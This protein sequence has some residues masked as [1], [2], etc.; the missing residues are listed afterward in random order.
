MSEPLDVR[1]L[2]QEQE[3]KLPT[4]VRIGTRERMNTEARE[5]AR[6]I[7]SEE[8]APIEPTISAEEDNDPAMEVNPVPLQKKRKL[9]PLKKSEDSAVKNRPKRPG[10]TQKTA[11]NQFGSTKIKKKFTVQITERV[12]REFKNEALKRGLNYPEL[13]E[14][15]FTNIFIT[16][17]KCSILSRR[18]KSKYQAS[19]RQNGNHAVLPFHVQK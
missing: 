12:V 15:A 5:K 3:A 4:D 6:Q 10:S 16:P 13:A 18:L 11:A 7:L 14:R 1:N 17:G 9:P 8:S 19:T 2:S